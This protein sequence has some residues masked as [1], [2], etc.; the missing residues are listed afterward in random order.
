[1]VGVEIGL[2]RPNFIIPQKIERDYELGELTKAS[3]PKYD[4]AVATK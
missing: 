1:M 3:Y 2:S 4:N